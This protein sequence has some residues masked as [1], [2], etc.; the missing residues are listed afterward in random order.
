MLIRKSETFESFKHLMIDGHLEINILKGSEY[1]VLLKGAKKWI[2]AIKF[3]QIEER[4]SLSYNSDAHHENVSITIY[5]P[6][7]ESLDLINSG[8]VIIEGF[9]QDLLKIKVDSHHDV[10]AFIEVT[11]LEL[12]MTGHHEFK[13]KGIGESLDVNLGG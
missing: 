2:D 4:L 13:L 6:S 8:K 7:I 5:A 9:K 3:S 12:E 10:S 1:K 11:K